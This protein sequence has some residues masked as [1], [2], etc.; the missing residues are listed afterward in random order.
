MVSIKL[1]DSYTL[2]IPIPDSASKD[3][4]F[5]FGLHKCGSSLMNKVFVD[6]C[7]S[8]RIPSISIPE[9]A[10][11]QGIPTKLWETNDDIN[12]VIQDGYCYRGF[13]HYPVFLEK[14]K[15]INERK[16]I[17]LVRD[18][19]DAIVSAYFSFAKSHRLPESGQLLED[20]VKS[21][22]VLQ[23][24]AIEDYA[25]SR[26]SQVKDAFN[27]YNQ[28]FTKD[29]LLKVYRY[30]D[31]IFNKFEWIKSM[32]DFLNLSL[33]D[34]KIKEIAQKH[35]IIPS[36]EDV[37]QHIRKAKPGDHKEKLSSEC[38]S[39]LNEILS[40]ILERYDYQD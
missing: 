2:D 4:F 14:N 29:S 30:E 5:I 7:R 24:I 8:V 18:P 36:N 40:D 25:L 3:A 15:L 19:R 23:S 9:V 34:N 12:S 1:D 11:K 37:E 16:K 20:M 6:V 27:R 28:Y 22:Q 33:E 21:R 32:L 26:A 38:I 35:D 31:I 17:L 39:K 10:F 13:R